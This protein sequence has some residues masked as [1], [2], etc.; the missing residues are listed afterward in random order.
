VTECLVTTGGSSFCSGEGDGFGAGV[1]VGETDGIWKN[2]R[3]DRK[4]EAN[5]VFLFCNWN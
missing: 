4:I 5:I 2:S 1:G 3:N